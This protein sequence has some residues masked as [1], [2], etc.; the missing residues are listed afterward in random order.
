[1][2]MQTYP[3][4]VGAAFLIDEEVF[5]YY[6]LSMDRR[7]GRVPEE[8]RALSA[9][10]FRERARNYSLPCGYSD[11]DPMDISCVIEATCVSDFDGEANSIILDK[12]NSPI[13][14]EYKDS[15]ICY[16]AADK[17]PSY[18]A[19]AYSSPEALLEEFKF[20]LSGINFPADFNWWGHIVEISGST[21][22]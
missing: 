9:D 2:S 22:A 6:C 20:R 8:I 12:T 16:I 10:E 19:A 14:A 21:F 1:M 17:E 3:I 4:Y 5:A 15:T 11:F 13:N 7:E 18:F